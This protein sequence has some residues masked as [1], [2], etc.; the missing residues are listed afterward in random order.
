TMDSPLAF[1]HFHSALTHFQRKL[2]VMQMAEP[3]QVIAMYINE[4]FP[5]PGTYKCGKDMLVFAH[6]GGL[7]RKHELPCHNLWL[8]LT[9]SRIQVYRNAQVAQSF[10]WMA[11]GAPPVR[12]QA[13]VA[14]TAPAAE[15]RPNVGLQERGADRRGR[16]G[17]GGR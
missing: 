4:S 3:S 1:S 10:L 15:M 9:S 12:P 7:H 14:L 6:S 11:K 17:G 5:A 16:G 13:P 2:L 8:D